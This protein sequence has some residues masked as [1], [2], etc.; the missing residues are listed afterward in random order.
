M[1]TPASEKEK[2]ERLKENK[3]LPTV[4][5]LSKVSLRALK[6]DASSGKILKNIEVFKKKQPQWVHKLNS[7]ASPSSLSSRGQ[8]ITFILVL[9]E[10]RALIQ[11][12][13]ISF[14]KMTKKTCG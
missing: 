4:T 11:N 5:V 3:G 9:M 1:E 14:G 13:V 6:I 7:Y 8:T 12:Q 10:M 2:E